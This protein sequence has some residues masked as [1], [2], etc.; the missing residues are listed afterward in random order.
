[1]TVELFLLV[2][3]R[4]PQ[5]TSTGALERVEPNAPTMSGQEI[6]I[7]VLLCVRPNRT[8]TTIQSP[9]RITC[10]ITFGTNHPTLDRTFRAMFGVAK[11][12]F[13]PFLCGGLMD[14]FRRTPVLPIGALEWKVQT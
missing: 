13:A 6:E 3:A 14:P 4:N 2:I 7:E 12:M 8:E 10:F 5:L 1:M 11:R 9:S